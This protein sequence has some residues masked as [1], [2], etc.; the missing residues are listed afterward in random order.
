M[1]ERS[2]SG[3][4]ASR[5]RYQ[6]YLPRPN[7]KEKRTECKSVVVYVDNADT[8]LLALAGEKINGH[9]GKNPGKGPPTYQGPVTAFVEIGFKV[10]FFFS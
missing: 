7:F 6:L 1:F 9:C 2:T 5:L 3:R 10:C 8:T 4:L